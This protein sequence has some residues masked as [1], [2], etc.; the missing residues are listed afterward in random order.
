MCKSVCPGAMK[1]TV[2]KQMVYK[3]LPISDA[4]KM[5]QHV[6]RQTCKPCLKWLYNCT[7]LFIDRQFYGSV[8]ISVSCTTSS[9]IASMSG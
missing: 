1:P 6:L 3:M 7:M 9:N 8:L 2:F 5:E 4:E